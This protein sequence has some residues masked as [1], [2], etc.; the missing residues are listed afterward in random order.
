[1]S[2]PPPQLDLLL[3]CTTM[4]RM[5]L[6]CQNTKKNET[7]KNNFKP[8]VVAHTFNPSTWRQRQVDFWVQGQPG[9]QSEFQDS[10]GYTEKP[11]LGKSKIK[12][13]IIVII[14]ISKLITWKLANLSDWKDILFPW[15]GVFKTLQIASWYNPCQNSIC[16]HC[17]NEQQ[18]D[19]KILMELKRAQNSRYS[20]QRE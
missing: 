6:A 17:T 12:I 7:L 2:P 16:L 13:I 8:G 4:A 18:T 14:I 10:Q 15:I 20:L 11:C 3:Y 19:P 5:W 9:L 1:M